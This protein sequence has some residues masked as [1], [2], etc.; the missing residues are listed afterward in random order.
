[1]RRED[2][3]ALVAGGADAV[4]EVVHGL[5]ARIEE[6]E[7]RLS[8]GSTNSSLPPSRDPPLT[9]QQRREL[10]RKRVK[11]C[12]CEHLFVGGEER[13]GDPVVHHKWELPAVA[14]LIFEHR[15]GGW[16]ARAAA[17]RSSPDCPPA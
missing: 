14:P 8:R 9:R 2:A 5:E 16:R 15:C 6:L 7:R 11:G 13:L 12:G 3:E 10:A 4:L 17:R 1:M